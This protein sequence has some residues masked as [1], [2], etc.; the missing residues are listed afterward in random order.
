MDMDIDQTDHIIYDMKYHPQAPL[1]GQSVASTNTSIKDDSSSEGTL[2]SEQAPPHVFPG[3]N[4]YDT[5]SRSASISPPDLSKSLMTKDPSSSSQD[6]GN[7]FAMLTEIREKSKKERLQYLILDDRLSNLQRNLDSK[8]G[9]LQGVIEMQAERIQCLEDGR[10]NDYSP[11]E[12]CDTATEDEL[13]QIDADLS[14]FLE[15]YTSEDN[16]TDPEYMALMSEFESLKEKFDL[17][18]KKP[19]GKKRKCQEGEI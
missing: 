7:L 5:W 3:Y 6:D 19:R 16:E 11:S 12:S 15:L 14:D 2:F 18:N 10:D 17:L 8:L 1:D 9:L 13:E 4:K